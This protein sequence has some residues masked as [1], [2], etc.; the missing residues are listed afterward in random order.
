[1][2]EAEFAET[3]LPRSHG[4]FVRRSFAVETI[5]EQRADV[6]VNLAAQRRALFRAQRPRRPLQHQ[7]RNG[8]GSHGGGKVRARGQKSQA[9]QGR[10][11]TTVGWRVTRMTVPSG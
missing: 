7:D 4:S 9:R 5:P 1:M 6:R 10:A 3:F 8:R 11:V 2:I